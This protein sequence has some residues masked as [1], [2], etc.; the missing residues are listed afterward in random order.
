[1]SPQTPEPGVVLLWACLKSNEFCS[2]PDASSNRG[3]VPP[4]SPQNTGSWASTEPTPIIKT[5]ASNF[6]LSKVSKALGKFPVSW[7][8]SWSSGRGLCVCV[9][10]G[11]VDS[12]ITTAAP[13]SPELPTHVPQLR[14]IIRAKRREPGVMKQQAFQTRDGEGCCQPGRIPARTRN[15]YTSC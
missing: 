15:F 1:M 13:H 3:V 12:I 14:P 6:Q 2:A 10:W 5:R 8:V 4:P 9:W 7:C 11:E